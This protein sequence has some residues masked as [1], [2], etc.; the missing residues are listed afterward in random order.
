MDGLQDAL[1]LYAMDK[2][3][4]MSVKNFL[5][6]K[7]S[8]EMMLPEKVIE[9]IVNHQFLKATDALENNSSIEFSGFGRFYFK[10]FTALRMLVKEEMKRDFYISQLSPSLSERRTESFNVRIQNSEDIINALKKKLGDEY[11]TDNRGMAEQY[12][13]SLASTRRNKE[14]E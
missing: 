5:I 8:V 11:I 3:Q 12:Y 13:S 6:R 9:A 4:S 10:K 7:L 1:T 2:P 14:G